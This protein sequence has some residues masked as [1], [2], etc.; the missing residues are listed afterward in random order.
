M[1]YSNANGDVSH[2][3]IHYGDRCS[4]ATKPCPCN[5]AAPR[6]LFYSPKNILFY[7]I[8]STNALIERAVG[9]QCTY[10]MLS[11]TFLH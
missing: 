3:L 5:R 4:P 8:Y 11:N 9:A 7:F 2:Y 6:R 1:S 10:T